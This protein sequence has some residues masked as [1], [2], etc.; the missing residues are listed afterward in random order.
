MVEDE[1]GERFTVEIAVDDL[2]SFL[3]KYETAAERVYRENME[4]MIPRPIETAVIGLIQE[5]FN[6]L[7]RRP[8][9]DAIEYR[10]CNKYITSVTE[11]DTSSERT[12]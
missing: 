6:L 4:N 1:P 2:N 12:T 7:G 8:L 9:L 3:R 5:F 10:L 11:Q